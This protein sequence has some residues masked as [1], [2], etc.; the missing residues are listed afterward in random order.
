MVRL[1]FQASRAIDRDGEA[2]N[3]G[4]VELIGLCG[5]RLWE[6]CQLSVSGTGYRNPIVLC[7]GETPRLGRC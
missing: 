5:A 1:A 3:D 2:G 6:Q 7:G 4:L